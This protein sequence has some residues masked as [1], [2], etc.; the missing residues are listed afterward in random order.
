MS[1]IVSEDP[2]RRPQA[3]PRQ[4]SLFSSQVLQF[5]DY[6][7][8]SR[9]PA[10]VRTRRRAAPVK[11]RATWRRERLEA[12][13]QQRLDLESIAPPSRTV[14]PARVEP[15]KRCQ[16]PVA[17]PRHRLTAFAI[18]ACV[19]LGGNAI[20][21]GLFHW[22]GGAIQFDTLNLAVGGGVAA[23]LTLFYR[24]LWILADGDTP[25]MAAAGLRLLDFDGRPPT[26]FQ[27]AVRLAATVF[28]IAAC[29]LGLLWSLGDT[30]QL[31]WN[32]H[33]SKT[34][35]SPVRRDD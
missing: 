8:P 21:V 4:G 18:D 9:V 14:N 11:S 3:P 15:A 20:F 22:L 7:A 16:N 23:G 35:P 31:A 27:R 5:E 13:G 26:R 24:V 32:D 28:S 33:L 30:E 29:G 12:A 1:V 25:G 2:T 34:F 6:S 19:V 17:T 10:P